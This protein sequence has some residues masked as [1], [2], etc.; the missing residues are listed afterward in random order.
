MQ[1]HLQQ[2]IDDLTNLDSQAFT[3]L[4]TLVTKEESENLEILQDNLRELQ[5]LICI[6]LS[7]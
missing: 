7:L 4:E 5:R 2:L 6:R 1:K 3:L